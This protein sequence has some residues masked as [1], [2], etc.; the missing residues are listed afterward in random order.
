M[1]E[2]QFGCGGSP[3]EKL[4]YAA[5]DV[6][7]RRVSGPTFVGLDAYETTDADGE[8]RERVPA[9]HPAFRCGHHR[10][11]ATCA[12]LGGGDAQFTVTRVH[13]S[14]RVPSEHGAC[15][16]C[17]ARA[18]GDPPSPFLI[19]SSRASAD[20]PSVAF[21]RD[22]RGG[23]APQWDAL[24]CSEPARPDALERSAHSSDAP[25]IK[26]TALIDSIAALQRRKG[27]HALEEVLERLRPS[28]RELFRAAL[29]PSGWYSLDVFAE[30]LRCT[31]QPGEPATLLAQ[32]SEAA[33]EHQLRGIYRMFVKL[34]TPTFVLKRMAVI[35]QTYFRGVTI[36][37][38]SIGK[39]HAFVRYAGFRPQH[40]I[41]EHVIVGFFRKALEL[42]GARG[43][44]VNV[45]TPIASGRRV[46]EFEL[47]WR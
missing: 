22:S 9:R 37:V 1:C 18:P 31:I 35:H 13:I 12:T 25:Q 5:G 8:S 7:V 3:A 34:G 21:V 26:G 2:T 45:V 10:D 38:E 29:S 32:R 44:F 19:S 30:F 20:P 16:R 42:S 15:R 17:H 4:R 39:R 6:I 46:A 33:I 11:G 28:W 40:E 36:E 23:D 14:R 24:K 47:N 41:L 43:C 27:P